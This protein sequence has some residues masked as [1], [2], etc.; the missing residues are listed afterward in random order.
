MSIEENKAVS[1]R[2][3]EEGYGR[4]NAAALSELAPGDWLL[5]ASIP[6]QIE[7]FHT[8]FPDLTVEV[9]EQIAE[10]DR[11]VTRVVFRGTHTGVLLGIEPTGKTMEQGLVEIQTVHLGQIS[12]PWNSFHPLTVLAQLG[13]INAG[14]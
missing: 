11:V 9:I 3:F 7:A 6:A 13:V 4:N 2:W 14:D 5:E 12:D 1:R 8:G 10:G